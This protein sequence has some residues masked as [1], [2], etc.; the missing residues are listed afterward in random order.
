MLDH[1]Y[2]EENR[3]EHYYYEEIRLSREF[4]NE[5]DKFWRENSKLIPSNLIKQYM[6]LKQHYER[7]IEQG[8]P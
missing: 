8:N 3:L 7:E 4:A 5:F 2:Y 6:L 1:Y